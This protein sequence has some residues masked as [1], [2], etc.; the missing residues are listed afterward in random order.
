MISRGPTYNEETLSVDVP[1]RIMIL[2]I[3]VLQVEEDSLCCHSSTLLVVK[4]KMLVV[5]LKRVGM[6]KGGLVLCW[7]RDGSGKSSNY[8]KKGRLHCV[9]CQF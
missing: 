9:E 1:A 7:S 3:M 4:L 6:R 2:L 5:H 8:V